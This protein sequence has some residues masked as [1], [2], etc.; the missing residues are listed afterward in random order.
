MRYAIPPALTRLS[1]PFLLAMPVA[2]CVAT[3][4]IA[5]TR[6]ACSSILPQAWRA[7]VEG[8]TL[9]EGDSVGEWIAFGDAQT[10]KL[11][12]S[13]GRTLDAIAI[14]ERCEARD[15]QGVERAR[16]RWWQIF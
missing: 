2:G 12:Q 1:I 10:A 13:N 4:P 9:P 11:D 3:P 6:P 16:R 14:I 15:A 7:P 8:A 5:T